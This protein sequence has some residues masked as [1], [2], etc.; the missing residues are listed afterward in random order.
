MKNR[1]SRL[2][3]VHWL[4][5]FVLIM[6][7]FAVTLYSVDKFYRVGAEKREECMFPLMLIMSEEGWK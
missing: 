6:I 3:R 4:V 7:V 2:A 1:V 5:I